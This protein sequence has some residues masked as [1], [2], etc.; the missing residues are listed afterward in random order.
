MKMHTF[1]LFLAITNVGL[2]RQL[3]THSTFLCYQLPGIHGVY[4]NTKSW[5]RN[6]TMRQVYGSECRSCRPDRRITG[7]MYTTWYRLC[8]YLLC[9]PTRTWYLFIYLKCNSYTKYT[10]IT[11]IKTIINMNANVCQ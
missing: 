6:D 4:K 1:T 10:N 9:R 7:L 8:D 5:I 3:S 11:K 2:F